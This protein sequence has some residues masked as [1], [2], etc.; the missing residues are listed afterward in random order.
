M[1]TIAIDKVIMN[2]ISR[3]R[4][5]VKTRVS[6]LQRRIFDAIEVPR[7]LRPAR[8][9]SG[10]TDEKRSGN[11]HRVFKSKGEEATSEAILS[12]SLYLASLRSVRSLFLFLKHR[13][14]KE[15]R[16]RRRR[17]SHSLKYRQLLFP[18]VHKRKRKEWSLER[19]VLG[20]DRTDRVL[21]CRRCSVMSR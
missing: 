8:T 5:C 14:Q 2:H 21:H 9:I 7:S 18:A 16:G 20:R 11:Y 6:E 15:H 4:D 12:L 13:F 10:Q 19:T 1:V 17:S 3:T